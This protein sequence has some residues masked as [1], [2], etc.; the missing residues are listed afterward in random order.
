[1]DNDRLLMVVLAHSGPLV[2]K[3][4]LLLLLLLR[5]LQG[6]RAPHSVRRRLWRCGCG[7]LVSEHEAGLN[8]ESLD[9]ASPSPKPTILPS[10]LPSSA[11][12]RVEDGGREHQ[13]VE[14][15]LRFPTGLTQFDAILTALAV[16]CQMSD[17][18]LF[19]LGSAGLGWTMSLRRGKGVLPKLL[20]THEIDGFF[21]NMNSQQHA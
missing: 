4:V 16:V 3:I 13:N 10:S 11:G 15:T 20:I 19:L 2:N 7:C 1:M 5:L 6:E 14:K 8:L 12:R 18:I 17:V 21:W 9:A